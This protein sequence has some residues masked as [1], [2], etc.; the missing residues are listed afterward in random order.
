MEKEGKEGKKNVCEVWI[1]LFIFY[2][3]FISD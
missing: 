1:L 2:L 3:Q